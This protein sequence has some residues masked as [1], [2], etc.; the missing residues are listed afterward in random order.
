MTWLLYGATGFTGKLIA[1]H[2]AGRRHSPLLAGRSEAK[3][4]PLA[5][6]LKLPYRVF[7][8]TDADSVSTILRETGVQAVLHAAGPFIDTADIMIQACLAAGVHYLDITGEVPVFEHAFGYHQAAETRGIVILPGVGFDVV[9]SD[10]LLKFVAER[11]PDATHLIVAITADD[12]AATS[13]TLK[14][15][16]E[17]MRRIGNVIRRDGQL[18]QVPVPY[19]WRTFPFPDGERRL[20]Q[21]P[22]G[23]VVTGYR[24]TGVPNIITYLGYGPVI[25]RQLQLLSR[26]RPLLHIDFIRRALFTYIERTNAGPTAQQQAHARV[27]VY[28]KATNAAGQTAEAWLETVEAYRFTAL[29]SV[30]AVERV[31]DGNFAGALT[32]ASAFGADFVLEIEGSQRRESLP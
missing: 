17:M 32:P 2:A 23:D 15:G 11:L 4:K 18:V 30:R 10:C 13:G 27:Q 22:W 3:L 7:E 19:E 25:I 16:T 28:A 8:L 1:E 29:S 12:S 20:A 21:V 6:R 5:D 14:S 24:S 9:P 31:L 26:I